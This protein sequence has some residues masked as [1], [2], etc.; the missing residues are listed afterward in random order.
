MGLLMAVS[1]V[2]SIVMAADTRIVTK[3]KRGGQT[4]KDKVAVRDIATRIVPFPNRTVVGWNVPSPS[5]EVDMS[6]DTVPGFLRRVRDEVGNK[7]EVTDLPVMLLTSFMEFLPGVHC[8]FLVGGIGHDGIQY[9][10]QVE[11]VGCGKVSLICG[12]DAGGTAIVGGGEEV[13]GKMVEVAWTGIMAPQQAA[14]F[15]GSCIDAAIMSH[16]FSTEQS[17][18]GGNTVVY[19]ASKSKYRIGWVRDGQFVPEPGVING[20][21]GWPGADEAD[22]IAEDVMVLADSDMEDD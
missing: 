18:V 19:A 1:C 12:G 20:P 2:D 3:C 8:V 15:C 13:V 5:D 10:Y 9:L 11:T 22:V 14:N 17:A 6:P 7:C 21:F 4:S 16:Q